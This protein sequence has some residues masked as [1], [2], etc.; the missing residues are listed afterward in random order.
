M[1]YEAHNFIN[2]PGRRITKVTIDGKDV[3]R[4]CHACDPE[5][6]WVKLFERGPDGR[7]LKIYLDGRPLGIS[8]ITV[9]GRVEVT[10]SNKQLI[11]TGDRRTNP[12]TPR[13][14]EVLIP[15]YGPPLGK[16][17]NQNQNSN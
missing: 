2:R 16:N 3:T 14:I 7:F 5:E 15:G 4:D 13:G 10:F 12:V 11:Y 17:Q 1:K 8:T 6:G 9:H